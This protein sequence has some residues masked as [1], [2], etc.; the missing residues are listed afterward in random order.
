MI[1]FVEISKEDGGAFALENN[2]G[3]RTASACDLSIKKL[4]ALQVYQY[5]MFISSSNF[6]SKMLDRKIAG[7][8]SPSAAPSYT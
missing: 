2:H 5:K 8:Q 6:L 3:T 7:R 4:K 1:C